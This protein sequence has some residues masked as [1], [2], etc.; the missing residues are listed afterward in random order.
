M[1]V[2]GGGELITEGFGLW[3]KW[4]NVDKEKSVR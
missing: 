2:D 4:I 3:R 1:I